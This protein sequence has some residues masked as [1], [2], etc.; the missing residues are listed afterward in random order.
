M[1]ATGAEFDDILMTARPT[2]PETSTFLL[3]SMGLT[4]LVVAR[5]PR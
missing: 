4:A 3:L 1:V 5:K 2:V